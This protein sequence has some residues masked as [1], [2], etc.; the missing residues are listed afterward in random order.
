M[1][2]VV[3]KMLPAVTVGFAGTSR[4][5]AGTNAVAG[6]IVATAGL[7]LVSITV[8]P[9]AGAT[10][11][12]DTGTFP[13]AVGPSVRLPIV[14][15]LFVTAALL[16]AD[17][18]GG[19]VAVMVVLPN[20]IPLIVNGIEVCPAG[21]TTLAGT[22]RILVLALD[23]FTV[24][25]PMG[26]GLGNVTV[27]VEVPANGVNGKVSVSVVTPSAMVTVSVPFAPTPCAAL[28]STVKIMVSF[29]SGT[30]SL[31]GT[32]VSATEVCPAKNVIGLEMVL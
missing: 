11:E 26:A 23:K 32:I 15:A 4:L 2:V 19:D 31:I 25:P 29:G 10:V 3:P 22:V 30:P 20:A 18:S 21:I 24:V 28:L 1:R 6:E 8:T 13:V 7:L 27:P 14:R 9:P 12:S 17:T 16:V 5:P